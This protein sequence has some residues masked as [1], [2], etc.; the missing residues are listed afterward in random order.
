[1]DYR[2]SNY[3]TSTNSQQIC[4]LN[5]RIH[6]L[7]NELMYMKNMLAKK[8]DI[9]EYTFK[10]TFGTIKIS[11]PEQ[12]FQ[13]VDEENKTYKN[14]NIGLYSTLPSI[15]TDMPVEIFENIFC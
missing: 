7:E 1:M 10:A 12:S 4:Q 6:D 3:T 5:S 2:N 9:K 11:N 15:S 13:P 14:V 8:L